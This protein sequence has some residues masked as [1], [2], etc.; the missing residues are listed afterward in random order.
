MTLYVCKRCDLGVEGHV[1]QAYISPARRK[2][3]RAMKNY[4][5]KHSLQFEHT[6][7]AIIAIILACADDT[8]PC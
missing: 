7:L 1:S 8:L 3:N 6:L 4:Y 5:D 2:N